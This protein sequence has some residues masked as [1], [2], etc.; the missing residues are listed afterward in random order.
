[1]KKYIIIL[2]LLITSSMSF[3]Q[4]LVR[5]SGISV[6]GIAR[7]NGGVAQI[8]QSLSINVNL[9]YFNNSNQEVV[10]ITRTGNITTDGFG[11]FTYVI[12]INASEF[13]KIA[14]YNAYL[15]I[16]SSNTVYVQ[17]KLKT[18]PYA[19]HAQNGVPTG[20]IISYAGSTPPVGWLIADGSAIDVK[21][22]AL[23][24]I[25]GANLPDLR[26]VFLRGT[27][28][29]PNPSTNGRLVGPSL[30][31]IQN[32]GIINHTHAFSW[33][34]TA[35]TAGDHSHDAAFD[36]WGSNNPIPWAFSDDGIE[37]SAGSADDNWLPS[38]FSTAGAHTH[39]YNITDQSL[40]SVGSTETRPANYGINYIVKI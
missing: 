2:L 8:N 31:Q 11:V 39:T 10:F 34:G 16:S 37:A 7:D 19:I 27:G 20:S 6:Q 24:A 18:V 33:T 9:Y 25:F 5:S 32:D 12:D 29:Q 40:N 30:R 4:A 21:Y 28:T 35:N 1:M 38:W 26:G 36:R 13:A 17:E 14:N 15:R 22:T 3:S 23:R